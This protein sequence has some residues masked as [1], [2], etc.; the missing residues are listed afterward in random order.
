MTLGGKRPY[1]VFHEHAREAFVETLARIDD[2][3]V[4]TFERIEITADGVDWEGEGLL[5]PSSTWTYLVT[6]TPFTTGPLAAM[7]GRQSARTPRCLDVLAAV[8]RVGVL[9]QVEDEA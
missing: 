7:A 9:P 8:D 4:A 5:G 6:D 2:E 1:E 3:I